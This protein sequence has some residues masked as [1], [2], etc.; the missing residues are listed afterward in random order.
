MRALILV[1]SFCLTQTV[2][3]FSWHDLWVTKDQQAKAMMDKGQFAEAKNTFERQDWQAA[4]AY[5][6][7]EYE[8]AA[9]LFQSLKNEDKDYNQ[10]NALAQTG[11]YEEAIKAYDNALHSN[12]NN[13]DAL[14]NRRIVKELLKK[15]KQQQNQD[16]QN[17][18]KQNQDKQNQDKQNQD[19]QNQDK[20][21]QDKQNQDK[22]NQDKQN[23]DKQNQDKQNQDK[24]NQD[25]Q[26]QDKQNQDKQNQD[27]QN[28]DKQNQDKQD[29]EKP[30][31]QP[32]SATEGKQTEA[33]REQKSAK[34]QWL[35]LIPDDPGGLMR[36]K[37]LR[38]HLRRQLGGTNETI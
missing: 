11:N 3:A 35:R 22:Q 21:N 25:K 27:K 36:E 9:T 34:E 6:A 2:H 7:G 19:K 5:R 18:D 1:V 23:Q 15:Q 4:S 38:D 13:K 17:Q 12:P 30:A 10:G 26:N 32:K 31:E 20:Q 33:E 14:Y 16:K 8:Q 29:K 37:F 28:Q 24:Q